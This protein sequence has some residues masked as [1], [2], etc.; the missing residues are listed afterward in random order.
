MLQDYMKFFY[1]SYNNIMDCYKNSY[2]KKRPQNLCNMCGKCCRVVTTGMSHAD[3]LKLSQ[4]GDERVID[5]L[6]IFEPYSSVEKA[7][8]ADAA[9]VN[10][11][12][13]MLKN[14]GK[15]EEDKLTFYCCKYI[16][17]NNLCSNYEERPLICHYFPSEPWTVVPHG[18]GYEGW[19]FWMREEDKQKIRL[20]KEELIE[21]KLLKNKN[22][23]PAILKKIELVEQKIQR[24]IDSYSKCGSI[25]W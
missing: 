21:L 20:L 4:E 13:S 17:D 5:F 11:I 3:L 10:N 15:F 6:S 24:S 2:L 16:Q 23:D 18:C 7:R 25:N 22:C 1:N 9:I 8:E 19:L 14:E 12:I